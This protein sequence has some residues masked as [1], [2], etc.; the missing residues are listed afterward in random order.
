MK[1]VI[2]LLT[3]LVTAC[4]ARVTKEPPRKVAPE[5]P[6]CTRI[7][8]STTVGT[9]FQV[10]VRGQIFLMTAW[11]AVDDNG[12]WGDIGYGKNR[13]KVHF[14]RE[15]GS[16]VATARIEQPIDGLKLLYAA[17]PRLGDEVVLHGYRLTKHARVVNLKYVPVSSMAP[18]RYFAMDAQIVGGMSGGPVVDSEGRVV[19]I[20]NY[21][22]NTQSKNRKREA[23]ATASYLP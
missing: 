12:G 19:G 7:Q 17:T 22:V 5:K 10:S 18:W 21:Q 3:V 9:V 14:D 11:H 20:M 13:P 16:D 2:V 23:A 6:V 15:G 8:G 4:A 1:R